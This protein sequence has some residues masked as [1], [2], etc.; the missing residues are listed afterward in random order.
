MILQVN[1]L[2]NMFLHC[3]Y[4]FPKEPA[5]F[6]KEKEQSYFHLSLKEDGPKSANVVGTQSEKMSWR[7]NINPMTATLMWP[8][9]V[10]SPQWWEWNQVKPWDTEV[11][12]R[13]QEHFGNVGHCLPLKNN[14]S[15]LPINQTYND[16]NRKEEML[17]KVGSVTCGLDFMLLG[18]LDPV[19]FS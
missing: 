14:Q 4:F 17:L 5:F 7:K 11:L 6:C 2:L 3:V 1:N 8:S 16:S 12:Q 10:V 15:L 18:W 9:G 19:Y 13:T